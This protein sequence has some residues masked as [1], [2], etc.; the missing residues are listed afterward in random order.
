MTDIP[1]PERPGWCQEEE[2]EAA[3]NKA[4]GRIQNKGKRKHHDF[5]N[6]VRS[7]DSKEVLF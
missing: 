5:Q 3:E 4:N 2:E 7:L 6:E 1:I